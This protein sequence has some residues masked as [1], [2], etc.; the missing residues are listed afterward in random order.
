MNDFDDELRRIFGDDRLAVP[1][2]T[3]AVGRIVRGARRRRTMRMVASTAASV[4]VVAALALGSM[5]VTGQFSADA[6]YEPEPAESPAMP[7]PELTPDP[8]TLPA[9][10]A[11]PS[12]TPV[13]DPTGAATGEPVGDATGDPTG[14][15]AGGADAGGEQPADVPVPA[16]VS[17]LPLF[18]PAAPFDGVQVRMTLAELQQV[19]GVQIT[20]LRG[21][22]DRPELCYGEFRTERAH[23]YISLR[24]A[25]GDP[26][27]DI[28]AAYEVATLV[29]DVPVRTPEGI[30]VGSLAA[31]VWAAYPETSADDGDDLATVIRGLDGVVS[32]WQ[33]EVTEGLVSQI[34]HDGLH[35]CGANPQPIDGADVTVIGPAGLGPIRI[36]MTLAELQAVDGV[37]VDTE[38]QVGQCYGSF[39]HGD[40]NG[41]ISV[42]RDLTTEG[43]PVLDE[44]WRVTML[45]SD[46]DVRTPEGIGVGSSRAEVLVAY[47][48]T[49][50]GDSSDPY[51]PVPGE[52]GMWWSFNFGGTDHITSF[53]LDGGQNC[54]G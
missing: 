53:F 47:P 4:G 27:E 50:E 45:S 28:M 36:G 1:S 13:G 10:A 8:V 2:S 17:G 43:A 18:D 30:G 15:S 24:G 38:N 22:S 29:P 3:D 39:T 54:A 42:R 33:F 34:V 32:F 9:P 46:A 40:T 49:V 44:E 51:V 48:G 25:I 11:S 14:S 6:G 7:A 19:P 31:D 16:D 52:P 21:D 5:A 37:Q 41:W 12:D 20:R 26:P 35:N 23:G